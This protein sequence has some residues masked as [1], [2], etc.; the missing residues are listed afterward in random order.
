MEDWSDLDLLQHP[1]VVRQGKDF[2]YNTHTLK[3]QRKGFRYLE[4]FSKPHADTSDFKA[5]EGFE[6][7]EIKRIGKMKRFWVYRAKLK[8]KGMGEALDR[9]LQ[10]IERNGQRLLKL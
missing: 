4:V 9:A 6:I 2:A 8:P 7:E 5:P 10:S 1:G 3:K